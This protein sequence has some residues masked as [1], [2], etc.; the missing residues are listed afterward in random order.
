MMRQN[1][2][3]SAEAQELQTLLSHF[4][5][6][7]NEIV[8]EQNSLSHQNIDTSVF[9]N[10]DPAVLLR[11]LIGLLE[12]YA[13]YNKWGRLGSFLIPRDHSVYFDCKINGKDSRSYEA[14][15]LIR[16]K[17]QQEIRL[18]ELTLGVADYF[19]SKGIGIGMDNVLEVIAQAEF[20]M[21]HPRAEVEVEEV[22]VI[23]LT[24]P[25]IRNTRV[26]N[27]AKRPDHRRPPRSRV[28]VPR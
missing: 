17:F 7:R 4:A 27:P 5:E 14:L 23:D 11:G 10:T 28:K 20:E 25:Q 26:P 1:L 22:E 3:S 8:I 15:L 21:Q 19:R 18:K 2:F 16:R 12:N 9:G 24:P 13:K 6:L